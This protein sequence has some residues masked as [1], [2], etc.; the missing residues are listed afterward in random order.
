MNYQSFKRMVRA[1]FA[2][3]GIKPKFSNQD[4]KFTARHEDMVIT[5]NSI[6]PSLTVRWD[7]HS[8]KPRQ[9]MVRPEALQCVSC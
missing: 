4:G 3:E 8:N 7:I 9:A 2:K 6:S 5:A 1:I